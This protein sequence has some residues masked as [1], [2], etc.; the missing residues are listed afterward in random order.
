MPAVETADSGEIANFEA[1]AEEWWDPS[2]KFKAL[3]EMN[4]V[5]L[6]YIF[7]QLAIE[8]DRDATGCRPFEGLRIA[9]IGCGGGLVA[10]PAARLGAAVTGIDAAASNIRIAEQHAKKMNLE[11]DYRNVAA[12]KLL[13]ENKK[14]DVV[15]CLEVIEHVPDP[16]VFLK[17]CAD[18]INPGGVMICSTLNRTTKSFALAIIGAEYIL[19]WLPRGSHDWNCFLKPDELYACLRQAGMDPID[20]K[21]LVFDPFRWSWSVSDADLQVNYVTA[22][23][24]TAEP[25]KN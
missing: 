4:P 17:I 23:R 2:G 8:F 21:G 25:A 14:F 19:G 11:I 13:A 6:D 10:E 18:L 1:I 22:S 7:A 5:R 20:R 16:L 9:D 3:H 12:E 15:L 24:K